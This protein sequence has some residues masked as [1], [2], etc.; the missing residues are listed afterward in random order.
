MSEPGRAEPAGGKTLWKLIGLLPV[1][2]ISGRTPEDLRRRVGLQKVCYVGQLG[3]SCL[4]SEGGVRWLVAPPRP[5]FVRPMDRGRLRQSSEG[6]ARAGSQILRGM[7][8]EGS[9]G[10]S[11]VT[12]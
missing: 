12:L 9:R 1:V 7:E 3:M 10:G 4:E 8:Q 6:K 5:A 2:V 11:P